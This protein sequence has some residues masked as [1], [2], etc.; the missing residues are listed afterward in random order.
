[1]AL[2][3]ALGRVHVLFGIPEILMVVSH[4]SPRGSC[5]LPRSSILR[6]QHGGGSEAMSLCSIGTGSVINGWFI[7]V[8]L[9]SLC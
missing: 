1:M 2:I 4:V 7:M 6:P 9:P 5:K 8:L 3:R